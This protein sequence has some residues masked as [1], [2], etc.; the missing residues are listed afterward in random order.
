MSRLIEWLVNQ[1]KKKYSFGFQC[2]ATL[3]GATLFL[4]GIPLFVFLIGKYFNK[5]LIFPIR[6]SHIAA[7]ICF[8]LGIPWVSASVLWQLVYGKGTPVPAVPTKKFLENGPYRYVR[9]PMMLGFF[10]Y[11]LGWTLLFNHYGDFLAAG[12]VILLLCKE[13]SIV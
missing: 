9:N 12:F 7:L 6:F 3:L 1:S 2:L 11:L 5:G 10:L 4:I 13:E 8:I